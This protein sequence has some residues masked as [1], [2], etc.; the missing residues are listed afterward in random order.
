M[1]RWN[2]L[3][4]RGD[5]LA[6]TALA[7]AVGT[8]TPWAVG[9]VPDWTAAILGAAG[10]GSLAWSKAYPSVKQAS[11][12]LNNADGDSIT[13]PSDKRSEERRVGKERTERRA[14]V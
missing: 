11:Q 12:W 4:G 14:A 3:A 13:L 7:A 5:A 1:Q 2:V 10:A 6:L 8:A 9:H